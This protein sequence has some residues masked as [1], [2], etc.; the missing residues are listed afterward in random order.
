M[1]NGRKPF[2]CRKF[3]F[4]LFNVKLKMNCVSMAFLS[5]V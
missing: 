5:N 1:V 2:L 4:I 3:L